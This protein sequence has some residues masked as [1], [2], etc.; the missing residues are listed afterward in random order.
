VT[1]Q[2]TS[3]HDAEMKASIAMG[4]ENFKRKASKLP[5]SGGPMKKLHQRNARAPNDEFN[6]QPFSKRRH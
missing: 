6:S 1:L 4:E 2:A 5:E 3:T